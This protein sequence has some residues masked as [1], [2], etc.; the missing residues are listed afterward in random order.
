M[1][2]LGLK[3]HFKPESI[4]FFVRVC[5]V[6]SLQGENKLRGRMDKKPDMDS[7]VCS[8]LQGPMRLSETG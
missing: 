5:A 4:L 3:R 1:V 8:L 7:L 6:L 2:D